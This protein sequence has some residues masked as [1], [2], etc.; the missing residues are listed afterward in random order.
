MITTGDL[1][2]GS[3]VQ[4]RLNL[5]IL[6]YKTKGVLVRTPDTYDVRFFLHECRASS[7]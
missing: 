7:S 5:I 1:G 2:L 6:S 3:A 4:T